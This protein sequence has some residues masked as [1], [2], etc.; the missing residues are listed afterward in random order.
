MMVLAFRRARNAAGDHDFA[1]TDA[2]FDAI[3]RHFV[4][5]DDAEGLTIVPY[6]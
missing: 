1:A 4:P 6:P 3:T 5:P 2:E